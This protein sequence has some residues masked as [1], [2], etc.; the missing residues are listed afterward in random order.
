MQRSILDQ[1]YPKAKKLAKKK[2]LEK[3]HFNKK[4]K[5]QW[6][7]FLNIFKDTE[8]GNYCDATTC[9]FAEYPQDW[10]LFSGHE[11]LCDYLN[12]YISKYIAAKKAK[13]M[14]QVKKAKNIE[15]K[16]RKNKDLKKRERK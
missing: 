14:A 11:D 1:F 16:I 9:R 7:K 4:E 5:V 3:R 10:I 2:F 15:R 13:L 6:I 12:N 8:C